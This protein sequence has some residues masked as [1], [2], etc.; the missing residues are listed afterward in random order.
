MLGGPGE[1]QAALS[2]TL[3]RKEHGPD[4][5]PGNR[6]CARHWLP[7]SLEHSRVLRVFRSGR[8]QG[9]K[10]GLLPAG[11][12]SLLLAPPSLQPI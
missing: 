5:F 11:C 8:S 9:C 12:L 10:W 3:R 6:A 1:A 2:E 7:S 4:W